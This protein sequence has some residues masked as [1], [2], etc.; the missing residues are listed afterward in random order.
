MI[1]TV[2]KSTGSWYKVKTETGEFLDARTVGKLRLAGSKSTNPV[3]VGD[4]VTI[5]IEEGNE[6][7]ATI[8]NV[9][10]RK[11]HLQ[12][13]SNKLSKHSQTLAANV[14][15]LI[16]IASLREPE[17]SFGFIDRCTVAAIAYN[18]TPV[19]CF[20][21]RDLW[22]KN[23]LMQF[24]HLVNIYQSAKIG[25]I[26]SS[27]Y[28]D[29]GMDEIN[30][31]IKNK[32]VLLSGHSGVGKSSILNGLN[33]NLSLRVGAISSSHQ[34][35]KHTTTFAEMYD[36]DAHTQ[37]IDTPGIRDFGIIDIP[38]ADLP[39]F[40]PE[41]FELLGKCKYYNCKHINEP[42]CQVINAVEKGVLPVS[43]YLSY[44]SILENQDIY[45]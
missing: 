19:I 34:K 37:V 44:I 33:P 29:G 17:T 41:M 14:D 6:Q 26:S 43:R 40:F 21:K 5:E 35:G 10:Q 22:T 28:V 32:R 9:E 30:A 11:N 8:K 23:D 3:A 18:I 42:D 24:D 45:K 16:I 4:V 36:L 20:N 31:I 39:N 15:L 12:R 1:A 7:Q 38:Q 27:C 25:V 13:K 2:Y